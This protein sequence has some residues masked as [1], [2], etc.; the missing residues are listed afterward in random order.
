MRFGAQRLSGTHCLWDGKGGPAAILH[1]YCRIKTRVLFYPL[2]SAA[3]VKMVHKHIH[4]HRLEQG[5]GFVRLNIALKLPHRFR[6]SAA[7]TNRTKQ[8]TGNGNGNERR[9]HSEWA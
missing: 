9:M 5:L 4:T 1:H 7:A 6:N 8:S 3:V 2:S